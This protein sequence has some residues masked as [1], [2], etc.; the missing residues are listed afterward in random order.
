MLKTFLV[1]ASAWTQ[2]L[3]FMSRRPQ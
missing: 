1:V 2:F 3:S